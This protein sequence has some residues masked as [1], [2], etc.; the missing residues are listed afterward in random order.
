MKKKNKNFPKVLKC[1]V[2]VNI[3][4]PLIGIIIY[5]HV[6]IERQLFIFVITEMSHLLNLNGLFLLL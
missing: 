1:D 2:T 3:Y 4:I 6:K 5:E